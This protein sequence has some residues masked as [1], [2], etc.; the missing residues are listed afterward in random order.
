[1]VCFVFVERGLGLFLI[2]EGVG[3]VV[4]L[5]FVFYLGL[6]L[7]E[8]CYRYVFKFCW[9]KLL[10]VRQPACCLSLHSP[11]AV[12]RGLSH[13]LFLGLFSCVEGMFVR[14]LFA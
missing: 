12:E 1:M 10:W 4:C 7:G 9:L 6:F 11:W 13:L 8:S 2:G 5:E 14:V 3:W